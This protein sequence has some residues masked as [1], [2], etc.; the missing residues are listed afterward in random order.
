MKKKSTLFAGIILIVLCIAAGILYSS[1]KPKTELGEKEVAVVVVHGDDTKT[2]Y[3][4]H[5]DAEYL[6]EVLEENG[7]IEGEDGPYGIF[8]TVVDGEV[9]DSTK[10][11]WWCITK[12]GERV[13]TSADEAP[14]TD[15]CQY[16]LTLTEGY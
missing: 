15:G 13:N 1:A 6:R 16:E 10:Q 12:E 9:A 8:I 3:T 2:D 14:V 11:Q 4:F 5:T 7:L